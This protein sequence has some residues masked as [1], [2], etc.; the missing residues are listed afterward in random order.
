METPVTESLGDFIHRKRVAAGMSLRAVAQAAGI[1][2]GA[3]FKIETGRTEQPAP[4]ILV[5]L[6][7]VLEV[8]IEDLYV[9]A[10]YTVPESLPSFEPYLR[11]KYDLP[12]GA[13]QQ[14]DEY[15]EFLRQRYGSDEQERGS[16][17]K[18]RRSA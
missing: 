18:H 1:Q 15:F 11:T 2:H 3:L 10:G 12:E 16:G 4:K 14:L 6:A 13:V 9:L 5:A 7:R 17:Q 8:E